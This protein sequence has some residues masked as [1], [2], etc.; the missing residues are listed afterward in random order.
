ML[1]GS[2]AHISCMSRISAQSRLSLRSERMA[3]MRLAFSLSTYS[4]RKLPFRVT[5]SSSISP[6]SSA[7]GSSSFSPWGVKASSMKSAAKPMHWRSPFLRTTLST[8]APYSVSMAADRL[9]ISGW[10]TV[11]RLSTAGSSAL[12]DAPAR[13]SPVIRFTVRR[14][15]LNFLAGR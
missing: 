12:A 6:I 14:L 4:A 7:T 15:V 9:S 11:P 1:Y 8:V 2:P 10:R 13:S 3:S 5:G